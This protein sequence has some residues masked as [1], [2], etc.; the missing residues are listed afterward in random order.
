MISRYSG[1]NNLLQAVQNILKRSVP[2]HVCSV[3][4]LLPEINEQKHDVSS[5]G[6][7]SRVIVE[8]LFRIYIIYSSLACEQALKKQPASDTVRIYQV[9]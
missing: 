1:D 7:S 6:P 5:E 3:V 4:I 9:T 2:V 8:F